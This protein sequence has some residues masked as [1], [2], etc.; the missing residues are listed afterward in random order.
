MRL[1]PANS[2]GRISRR[3]IEAPVSDHAS[4]SPVQ[5]V[6]QESVPVISV[7]SSVALGCRVIA[8]VMIVFIQLLWAIPP[9]LAEESCRRETFDGARYSICSFN[10]AESD[11][12]LFWRDSAGNPYRSFSALAEAVKANGRVLAFAINAGMYQTDFTPVGLYVENGQELRPPKTGSAPA[13]LR[14]VPNF[15]RKPNG[16][17]FIRGGDAAVLTTERF[18][19]VRPQTDHASQSGPMLVIDGALNASFRRG[20]VQRTYRSGVGVSGTGMV[21]F[22][23]SDDQVNFYAFARLFRDLLG[24]RN[25]LFLDGGRGTGLYSPELGR[26]DVSWH[27]GFGPMIGAVK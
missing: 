10:L 23:I 13:D 24:C 15:Y 4:K 12:R 8:G 21:H 7:W 11:L 16:V 25:A 1:R 26:A 6:T 2:K 27:G 14:P 17:F 18:L 19:R 5:K 3:L 22:A 9:A 20:S